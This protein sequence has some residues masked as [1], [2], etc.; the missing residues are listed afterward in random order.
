[1]IGVLII[2][3]EPLATALLHC[4]RH[5]YG[6]M[7]PQAAALDV[8]P[9]ED[10]VAATEA[11]RAL[12][13]R[14]NDGSG[15]L[16]LTDLNGATPSRIAARLAE[17]Y[18][19]VVVAGVNLPLLLRAMNYRKGRDLETLVDML[20]PAAREAIEPVVPDVFDK[21]APD[22]SLPVSAPEAASN[23]LAGS[24]SEAVPDAAA[25]ALP[26]GA[27]GPCA[28]GPALT[29]A[30]TARAVTRPA[31]GGK[32]PDKP[33]ARSGDKP[34]PRTREGSDARR[35]HAAPRTSSGGR[36]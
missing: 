5:V 12:A 11:A 3:H 27:A 25:P 7:L 10:P 34:G 26:S 18:R 8:V 32:A 15:V 1:M 21:G 16:V 14:I 23:P 13:D 22:A 30:A 29:V 33:K 20:L 6:R 17:P 24:G 36:R 28:G 9:D 4:T 19:I 35:A 2:S 31:P